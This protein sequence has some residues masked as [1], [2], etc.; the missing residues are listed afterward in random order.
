M[1]TPCQYLV[2]QER[3][4][5]IAVDDKTNINELHGRSHHRY[6]V[7][8]SLQNSRATIGTKTQNAIDATRCIQG[9][10][11]HGSIFPSL[12][13]CQRLAYPQA[14][15]H[16]ANAPA[17]CSVHATVRTAKCHHKSKACYPPFPAN[18][19]SPI[20][21]APTCPARRTSTVQLC[22]AHER[23]CSMPADPRQS[24][25]PILP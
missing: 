5:F 15:S 12:P 21:I 22:A 4:D 8:G 25:W 23:A 16:H 19:A 7:P 14:D 9:R 20:A 18:R 2:T 3:Q 10:C 24:R 11:A 6:N 13:L 17:I 1:L